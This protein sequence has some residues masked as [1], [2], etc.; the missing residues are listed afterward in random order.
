[1]AKKNARQKLFRALVL[2]L[3]TLFAAV[4][5]FGSGDDSVESAGQASQSGVEAA[6]RAQRSDVWLEESGRVARVLSDD[7][8]GSRHQRFILELPSGHTVLVAHNIDLAERVPLQSGDR[9]ELRGE[10]EYNAQ[11]GVLHWTHHDP[12]GRRDGGWIRHAGREY[13]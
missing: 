11:G 12:S 8:Q 9:L 1:M 6:F 10:Y 2:A 5:Y 7:N 4:A 13:R 3:T